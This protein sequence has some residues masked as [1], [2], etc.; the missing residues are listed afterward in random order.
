MRFLVETI[1]I[2]KGY[3]KNSLDSRVFGVNL[4]VI[5]LDVENLDLSLIKVLKHA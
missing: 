1:K 4:G 2:F 3:Y 5:F